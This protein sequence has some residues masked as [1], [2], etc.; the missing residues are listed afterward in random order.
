MHEFP[1]ARFSLSDFEW[2]SDEERPLISGDTLSMREEIVRAIEHAFSPALRLR[3]FCSATF[4]DQSSLTAI[5]EHGGKEWLTLYFRTGSMVAGERCY[6]CKEKLNI[7]GAR[8]PDYKI[9]FENMRIR[10]FGRV[11]IEYHCMESQRE[12]GEKLQ[13]GKGIMFLGTPSILAFTMNPA[14]IEVLIKRMAHA[15]F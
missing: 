15:K 2:K 8:E 3:D 10:S 11:Q 6:M 1:K 4:D 9:V 7:P 12:A 14:E 13:W 5:S